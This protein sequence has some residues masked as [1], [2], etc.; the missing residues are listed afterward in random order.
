MPDEARAWMAHSSRTPRDR[1]R[2]TENF[3]RACR[4]SRTV[5]AVSLE[6]GT[7]AVRPRFF[8]CTHETRRRHCRNSVLIQY[9]RRGSCIMPTWQ[10]SPLE[11]ES[12]GFFHVS[13]IVPATKQK[14]NRYVC[15]W[16]VP[17]N[18]L[19]RARVRLSFSPYRNLPR[20]PC[21]P[22]SRCLAEA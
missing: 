3:L 6:T 9:G 18:S 2:Q 4:A 19:S 15:S 8:K 10:R 20:S 5:V 11:A 1:A 16:L 7:S 17:S 14:G 22:A 12:L 21:L 13:S